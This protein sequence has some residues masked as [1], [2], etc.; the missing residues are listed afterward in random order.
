MAALILAEANVN[1]EVGFVFD[2]ALAD[3]PFLASLA[4]SDRP[5][6]RRI[7]LRVA[8]DLFV[9]APP[10]DPRSV[11]EFAAAMAAR[12]KTADG[13]TRL[14]IA[15]KLA[16][17]PDTPRGLLALFVSLDPEAGRFVL[18]HAVAY[19]QDALAKAIARGGADAVAA[20]KRKNPDP[21]LVDLLA[22]HED[23]DVL[24][25]LAG[26]GFAFLE[27]PT[28]ARLMQKARSLAE[29]EGDRRLADALLERKPLRPEHGALFLLASPEQRMDIL[30]AAQR[31][32]LGLGASSLVPARPAAIEALEVAAVTRQR[33]P[34]VAALAEALDCPLS[35]ARQIADDP[36]GEPLA[37]ALAA[38][39][40]ANE[41]M[42]RVLIANDLLSG[43]GYQ[44]IRALSRLNKALNRNAAAEVM[45]ALRSE[46]P[47][48]PPRESSNDASERPSPSRA[49]LVRG[50]GALTP[51]RRAALPS[52][53]APER[54]GRR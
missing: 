47:A 18:E 51:A 26:N 34:F 31:E 53:S 14:E 48:R 9:A 11:A 54:V 39:G 23:V 2:L 5:E 27:A 24:V 52:A 30:L 3:F 21:E 1:G 43:A 50:S 42:V 13:E 25:A 44:R 41:A 35:L 17:S 37:V 8:S 36:S 16:P 40:M 10:R 38:V 4:A 15:R 49:S 46:K 20:A 32:Q 12:L 28:L 33:E 45:A 29:L 7:W 6:D 22:K 19:P